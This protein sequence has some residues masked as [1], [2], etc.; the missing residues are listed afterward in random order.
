MPVIRTYLTQDEINYREWIKSI[1]FVKV[2]GDLI[3]IPKPLPPDT[4][5]DPEGDRGE[6]VIKKRRRTK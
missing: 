6:E 2:N 5:P 1:N 4:S 3:T